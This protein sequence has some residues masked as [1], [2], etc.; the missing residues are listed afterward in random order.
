MEGSGDVVGVEEFLGRA[1]FFSCG[2]REIYESGVLH[3]NSKQYGRGEAVHDPTKQYDRREAL[4]N[5]TKHYGR[6]YMILQN[7]LDMISDKASTPTL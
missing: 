5:T 3:D 6:G 4:H 7:T 2:V 1:G